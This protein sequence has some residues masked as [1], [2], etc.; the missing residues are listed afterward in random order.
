MADF[1]RREYLTERDGWICIVHEVKAKFP[2]NREERILIA[3]GEFFLKY[4]C[5]G[6]ISDLLNLNVWRWG[7]GRYVAYVC[8]FISTHIY[9]RSESDVQSW[10]RITG[11]EEA[12]DFLHPFCNL[13]LLQCSLDLRLY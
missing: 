3:P 11:I 9:T 2:G 4:G 8:V 10:L 6:P 1:S 12:L 5:Q 7:P 13:K